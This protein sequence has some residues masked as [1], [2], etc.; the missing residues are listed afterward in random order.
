MWGTES[1][2][3]GGRYEGE[4]GG[5]GGRYDLIGKLR[6]GEGGTYDGEAGGKYDLLCSVSSGDGGR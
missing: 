3:D 1:F 5:G 6:S 4:G 2:G